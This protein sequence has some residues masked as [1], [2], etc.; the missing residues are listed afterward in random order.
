MI[1]IGKGLTMLQLAASAQRSY[2]LLIYAKKIVEGHIDY[3]VHPD[4]QKTFSMH[5]NSKTIFEK[6]N[7]PTHDQCIVPRLL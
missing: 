5:G 4:S 3:C 6:L 1:Y 7:T 2:S